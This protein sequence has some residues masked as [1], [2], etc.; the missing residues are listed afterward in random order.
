MLFPLANAGL[1]RMLSLVRTL[2]EAVRLEP[3]RNEDVL[4]AAPG[5]GLGLSG[6]NDG[7]RR[8]DGERSSAWW[9]LEK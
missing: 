5:V 2:N 9:S 3:P 8:G 6:E 7:G 4:E 1:V